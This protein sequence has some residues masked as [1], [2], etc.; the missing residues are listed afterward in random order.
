MVGIF[1]IMLMISSVMTTILF[2][3]DVKVEASGDGPPGSSGVNLDYNYVWNMTNQFSNVIRNVNWSENG[4]NGIPKG[5]AWATAGENYTIKRILEPNMNGTGTNCS[6][7]GYQELLIGYLPDCYEPP[8]FLHRQ[9]QYSSKIVINDYGLTIYNNSNPYKSIPYSEL[10]PLGVGINRSRPNNLNV[11]H[12]FENATIREEDLFNWTYGPDHHN[13]SCDINSTCDT[14]VGLAVYLNN[15][16]SVPENQDGLVFIMHEDPSCEDKLE[17]VTSALG[18]ILIANTTFGGYSYP[19]CADVNFALAKVDPSISNLSFVLDQITNG[20]DYL[21]DNVVNNQT[22]VF[23]N[24][25]N[26]SNFGF[27]PWIGVIRRLAPSDPDAIDELFVNSGAIAAY[28]DFVRLQLRSIP[29]YCNPMCKGLILSDFNDTHFMSHTTRDWGWFGSSLIFPGS[30]GNRWWVPMFSVN[31]SIGDY[32]IN[33]SDSVTVSGFIN[34]T[35]RQQNETTPGVTSHNVVAYRNILQSPNDAIA[36]LSNRIDGWWSETPGDSGVGGAILLGIAKYFNDNNITAKYNLTFLFTTGEEYG[37]RGAQHYVDSHPNGTGENEFNFVYFIGFD[38]L[39]FYYTNSTTKK[40]ALEINTKNP[41]LKEIVWAIAN[42]TDYVGRNDNKYNI[43]ISASPGS[44]SED[45]VW[46]DHCENTV[47]FGRDGAWDGYH[48]A[49]KNFSLGDSLNYIDRNDVNVTFEIAWNVT[50]YFTVNPNC[51]FDNISFTPFDSPNDGDTLNDS[52]RTN[53]TIHSILPSDRVKVELDL[54]YNIS[55]EE[56]FS[57]EAESIDYTV[58]NRIQNFSYIFTIPDT[59]TNGYYQ[60]SFKLYNSTG[61]INKIVNGSSGTYYNDSSDPSNW[62]HLYHP[63]GYTKSGDSAECVDDRICGSV[64]TANENGYADNITAFINQAYMSPGPYQCMLYRASDGALIGNTTSDWVSLPQGNPVSSSWWAVFNFT[65]ERPFLMKGTQYIITCWGNSSYSLV[66]YNESGSSSTGGYCN[67]TYGTPPPSVEFIN[68]SRFY[69]IYCSY[70]PVPPMITNVTAT[71][72]TV[73]F[74]Y[75]VTI[76]ANV[77]DNGSG[78]NQVKIQIMNPGDFNPA[79][80]SNNYTMTHDSGDTYYYIFNDTWVAGQYNYTIWAISN[81]STMNS[82]S[83]HH[84]HVSVDASISIA[85]LEDTYS[86]EEYI[87][88][89]DPPNPP[90]NLTVMG[91]GLTWDNY[92]NAITGQN[93]LEVCTGPINYQEDNGMWTPINT[94]INQLESNHPAYVYGYRNG[95][96]QGLYGVYFKSNAQNDWPIAFKYNRSEDPTIHVIRSK[97]VGVGYVDPQNNWAYE[98]LQNVQSSQGQFI[99]NRATYEDVFTGTDVTWSYGNTGLKEEIALSNATQ[100]MLQNHPP[101]QYGLNNESSYLVFITKLDHQNLNLYNASG[102]L[103]GNVT[104]SGTGIDFKDALGQFKCALPLGEAY[105]LNNESVRQKLT[106]RIVHLNGN[107]YLLSGLK[108][109]DLNNMRYPVVIDPT[110]TVVSSLSDGD[111]QRSD[112]VYGFAWSGASGWVNNAGSEITIGQKKYLSDYTVWRGFVFFNTSALSENANISNATLSLYKYSDYS[113]TDFNVVIQNGQPTYPHDPLQSTDYNKNLYSGD[114]GSFNTSGF[115]SGYNTIV[116]TDF[117]WIAPGG[118]TKFCLR[119]SRDISGTAP[120]GNEYIVIH[121]KYD[122][123]KRY[124]P[125]LIITYQNQSKI[126][127]TGST[128]IKGYLLM[129]VQYF[130][131]GQFP[132]WVVDNDGVNETLPRTITSGDQLPLDLIFNGL[133]RASDLTHGEGTYRVYAAFRDPDGNILRTNDDVALEAWWQFS[134]T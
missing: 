49:G 126:N 122:R 87:N 19:Y 23:Q 92:Y 120:T 47:L 31:K 71:P 74:G 69:S 132:P 32:L 57:P 11:D 40:I 130:D 55:G 131:E 26:S 34:Q 45:Y 79:N 103:T 58:T 50:K 6:L 68:Q 20:Y 109:S 37:M 93:I 118:I 116:L 27:D 110:L 86:G 123:M 53:F 124:P 84:F 114:G 99:D 76:S 67:H 17:N 82:S 106:Y 42:Q 38:Q 52:I 83:G 115:T 88:I 102:L 104:I 91:R 96:D 70:S 111:I 94:T 3:N 35:Y 64:F 12:H 25:S 100:V 29:L 108:V 90:E 18:C 2:S 56:G 119:S 129:Q 125:K 77:S 95:N 10:F 121:A 97:L 39:G 13:V 30:F 78:V 43:N 4:G 5:R 54:G 7:S 60:V 28:Y 134:K 21:V 65:G 113:T 80:N 62:F 89:T 41:T 8:E 98:Y 48:R 22:L 24:Y 61:R 1:V 112:S 66:N 128:D 107:T 51:W 59:V 85:T 101:S 9:K 117:D 72:H 33:N 127:N 75:N 133:I 15:S 105:E 36:V 81:S 73:G 46:K 63:L 14:L 16:G 44:G